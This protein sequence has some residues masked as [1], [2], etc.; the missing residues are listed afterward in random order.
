MI[1]IP[2][3]QNIKPVNFYGYTSTVSCRFLTLNCF[4]PKIMYLFEDLRNELVGLFEAQNI[5]CARDNKSVFEIEVNGT[6]IFIGFY[7]W[8]IS[9]G[10]QIGRSNS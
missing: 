6:H 9:M 2:F 4:D 8:R 1:E 5:F 3:S 7:D 10:L